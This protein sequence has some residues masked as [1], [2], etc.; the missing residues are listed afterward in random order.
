MSQRE[1]I[2]HYAETN[3]V[4]HM[5]HHEHDFRKARCKGKMRNNYRILEEI[6]Q[7]MFGEIYK[8]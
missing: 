8:C 2:N 7:G 4:V 1:V 3:K 6:G 5:H